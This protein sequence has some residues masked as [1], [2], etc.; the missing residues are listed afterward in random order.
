MYKISSMEL[1]VIHWNSYYLAHDAE[2]IF[3]DRS[4]NLFNLRL[5]VRDPPNRI[6][7]IADTLKQPLLAQP[8]KRE[9][10]RLLRD[11]E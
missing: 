2:F 7:T 8:P 11:D 4:Y 10:H 9:T 6:P 5:F 3:N 1:S